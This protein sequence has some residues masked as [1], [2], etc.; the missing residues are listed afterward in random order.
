VLVEGDAIKAA[1][2]KPIKASTANV[3]DCASGR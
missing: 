3:I 1:S 2:A